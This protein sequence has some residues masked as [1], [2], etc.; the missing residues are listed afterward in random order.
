MNK[1]LKEL[2]DRRF[3]GKRKLRDVDVKMRMIDGS[4]RVR[5]VRSIV[6]PIVKTKITVF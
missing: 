6:T 1:A 5:R 4:E 3:Y 2:I